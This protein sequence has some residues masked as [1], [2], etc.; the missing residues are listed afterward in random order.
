LPL[1]GVRLADGSGLSR[2]DRV[3]GDALVGILVA[4]WKDPELAGPF[5]ESLAVAGISGTL[6][7]RLTHRPARGRV[8]AKTGTT[9]LASSLAGFVGGR[10]AFAVIMNGHPVP[11]WSA[12]L[13]QDRFVELLAAQ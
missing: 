7:D 3:T 5:V 10:Y 13:A 8:F 11:W 1:A 12:R 6:E 4:A 9:D 2:G